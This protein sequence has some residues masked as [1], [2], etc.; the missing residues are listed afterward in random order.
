[1]ARI[2]SVPDDFSPWY[3]GFM[4]ERV[5]MVGVGGVGG[6]TASGLVLAGREV[7]GVTGRAA[8][9][10]AINQD[11][12]FALVGGEERRVPMQAFADLPAGQGPFDLA[13]LGVPP[14]RAVEA[15][16]GL[17]PHLADEAPI[18]CFQNGLIEEKLARELPECAPRLV[19]G[20]VA[21]GASMLAP[22]RVEKTSPGGFV[23][24][25]LD[26]SEDAAVRRVSQVLSEVGDVRITDNLRGARW[27]KLA[28]NC[29]ISS[30]GTLGGDRLG[31]LMRHRYV[32]RL[33]LEV[34][35]EVTQVAAAEGV[36]LEKV[37]GTL[38]LDWL[39]LDD[40]ERTVPGSPGLVAKHTVLLAVGAKYRRLRSSMLAAIER[41]REP[42]VDYLNGEIVA[43]GEQHG[44]P[45]PINAGLVRAVKEVSA[46]T[47]E[48]SHEGVRRFFEDTRQELRDL[49][50]AA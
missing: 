16:R 31:S 44:I 48:A 12:L 41:G 20:I 11:G 13:L 15:V 39:A 49:R 21:F 14:D 30:L 8:I 26:G 33:C 23:V 37:A 7:V 50:L 32:R 42:P 35:T 1:L 17:L 27:S 3:P 24:G 9:A 18:V 4:S 36:Q 43:R 46:G 19:G 45:V 40:D 6:V 47:R 25:R 5:L 28:I 2:I 38:D 22:G 10:D 29:G 34:M